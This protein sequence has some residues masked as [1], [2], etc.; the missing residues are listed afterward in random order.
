[1]LKTSCLFALL[2]LAASFAGAQPSD[3]DQIKSLLSKQVKGWNIGNIEA[4]MEGYWK[5]DSLV[6]IG[7]GG[8]TY[9]FETTLANY[10]KSYPDTSAMGKLA[11]DVL[12]LR[13]LSP[14]YYL[15]TG[16]WHLTRTP[17]N[18]QGYYTLLLK[19]VNGKWVIV[20]DHSS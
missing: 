7:K 19:K 13:K 14:A 11:F 4:F 10:K 1:M 3:A 5:N 8:P 20:Y 16:K 17:G 2:L 12:E 18:L 9:G 15:V 6:F